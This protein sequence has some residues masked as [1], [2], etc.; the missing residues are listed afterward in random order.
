MDGHISQMCKT[1][2]LDHTEQER[3]LECDEQWTSNIAA[4]FSL[5]RREYLS[6]K[7]IEGFLIESRRSFG[8]IDSHEI[9][10]NSG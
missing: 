8:I 6:W 9:V 4:R 5:L 1:F 2:L 7:F 3:R 10:V